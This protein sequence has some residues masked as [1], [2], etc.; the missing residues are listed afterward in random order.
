MAV[1]IIVINYSTGSEK[2]CQFQY[3]LDFTIYCIRGYVFFNETV[4]KIFRGTALVYQVKNDIN[5]I[6]C[7]KLYQN[8]VA[9]DILLRNPVSTQF[10]TLP[11]SIIDKLVKSKLSRGA[12]SPV[13]SGT[14]YS[15]SE[16]E[17]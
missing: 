13:A 15:C 2:R 9:Y 4:L 11:K 7:T 17:G 14:E 16:S 8:C 5:I 6:N 12:G 3:V 10:L 1:N